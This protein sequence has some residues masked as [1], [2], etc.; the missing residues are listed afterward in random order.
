MDGKPALFREVFFRG[1][2]IERD[3]WSYRRF[4]FLLFA[5]RQMGKQKARRKLNLK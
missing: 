4:A 5:W 1:W 3:Q 2:S